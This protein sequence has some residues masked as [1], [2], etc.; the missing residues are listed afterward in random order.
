VVVADPEA[1]QEAVEAVEAL[2]LVERAALHPENPPLIVL[3]DL[4]LRIAWVEEALYE[5]LP[6]A[7]AEAGHIKSRE[8]HRSRAQQQAVEPEPKSTAVEDTQVVVMHHTSLS[9]SGR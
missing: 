8:A 1:P 9:C 6:T 7:L 3:A 4:H 2:A 5:E